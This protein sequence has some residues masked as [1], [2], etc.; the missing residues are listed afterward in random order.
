MY[1]NVP[2]SSQ[3]TYSPL[4]LLKRNA[5]LPA[6]LLSSHANNIH[7]HPALRRTTPIFR[8]IRVRKELSAE[9]DSSLRSPSYNKSVLN[10]LLCTLPSVTFSTQ[11][12]A[13]FHNGSSTF[14]PRGDVV[15]FHKLQVKLFATN[16]T[17]MVLLFPYSKFDIL[18]ECS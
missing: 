3:T 2:S 5:R 18:W 17:N 8:R 16:R 9:H 12:L 7:I 11:H 6:R 4:Q 10:F 15:S 13:I 1:L 14:A